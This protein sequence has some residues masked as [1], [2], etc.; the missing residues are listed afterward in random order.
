LPPIAK[1]LP[2]LFVS[3]RPVPPSP[4]TH[5]DCGARRGQGD[6]GDCSRR[7]HI[8]EAAQNFPAAA[9]ACDMIRE[10]YDIDD[11]STVGGR[12]QIDG[13]ESSNN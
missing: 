4:E 1:S 5:C 10:L 2:P 8:R 6:G 13:D 9:D 12:W 3:T 11:K 7:E